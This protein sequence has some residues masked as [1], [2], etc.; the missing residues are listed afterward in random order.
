M[1]VFVL[2][3][4]V[5]GVIV[6]WFASS[7]PR[8]LPLGV[9]TIRADD[10]IL[11]QVHELGAQY[12]VQVFAW[13]TI[14]PSPGRWDW[15]Y[16]DWLVRAA[17][18]Y[19]LQVIARLDKSPAWAVEDKTAV[20][21]PPH[22]VS[23]YTEFV[24]RVVERYRGKIPAYIVWNEP[25][26]ALEWGNQT[27]NA[28]EYV[29][30]LQHAAAQIRSTDPTA[31]VIAAGL[32]PTNENSARARDDRVF[33][34]EMYAAGAK[35]SFDILAA[36]PYAFAQSPD[37]P[38]GASDGLNFAR[39][40]DLRN[41][42]VQNGDQEKPIWITEFGYP[43]EQPFEYENRVVGEPLQAEY[44][45]RAY[46]KTRDELPFVQVFTIWNIVR[47]LPPS[48]EQSGYSL[49][50]A[51]GS[52]KP[53]FDA[54][55]NLQK[56]SLISKLQ[57]RLTSIF[58]PVHPPSSYLILARDA[59][60]HLGDSEY[61]A[62]FVPLYE[63]VNP[64]ADWKGEFY[65]TDA[66]LAGARRTK[67]WTLFLELMQVNDFDTRVWINDIP[68]TPAF[69]PVEDFTGKWVSAQFKIPASVLRVGYNA[70]SVR[71]GKLFPAFQQV[72]FTWDDFQMRNV[73]IQA[74]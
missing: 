35:D 47:S 42:M 19:G 55:K 49:V 8:A 23:D 10:A 65:L 59:V 28:A 61:P 5:L 29:N 6:I 72:G 37:A 45:A 52:L 71:N 22:K 2:V 38:H 4:L 13:D 64:S 50:R 74:P 40:N 30:L 34:R 54:V 58:T 20:S 25:N 48:N 68:L 27:P 56:E 1:L 73:R 26:L 12:L 17:D 31:R 41:V 46:D 66:D 9:H 69:L 7:R 62:P 43:T 39:I 15:E 21:S 36:H 53:A 3:T 14:E 33:L 70:V 18:Y 44:L 24:R 51:D 67:E 60:V 57:G 32:A 11:R 63:T 16:M